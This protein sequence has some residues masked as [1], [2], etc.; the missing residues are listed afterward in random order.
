[1]ERYAAAWCPPIRRV[2]AYFQATTVA[3]AL[4]REEGSG[5]E[6]GDVGQMLGRRRADVGHS[7]FFPGGR[8]EGPDR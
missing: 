8:G 7:D 3:R 1:M 5:G 6:G 2:R 4:A